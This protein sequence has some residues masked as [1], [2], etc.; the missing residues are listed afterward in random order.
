MPRK[1]PW[2]HRITYNLARR[3]HFRLFKYLQ[4]RWHLPS[5][6]IRHYYRCDYLSYTEIFYREAK[7]YHDTLVPSLTLN[8]AFIRLCQNI[9]PHTQVLI[10]GR[11]LG[12]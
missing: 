9:D 6:F 3:H 5:V 2:P 12:G 4:A 10:V 1:S 8:P 11:S 7:C